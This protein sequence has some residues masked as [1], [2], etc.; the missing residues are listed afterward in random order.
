MPGLFSSTEELLTTPVLQTG[1]LDDPAN[2]RALA[3][4]SAQIIMRS[5][6]TKTF[7]V[8]ETFKVFSN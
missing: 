4:S 6:I 8:N 7:T 5:I 1:D 2:N 3:P